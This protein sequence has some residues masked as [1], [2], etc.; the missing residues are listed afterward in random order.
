M[1]YALIYAAGLRRLEVVK[2]LL[3]ESPDLSVHEPIYDA[4]ARSV[5]AYQHYTDV[6]ALLGQ[7]PD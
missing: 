4:T 2:R 1:E 6:L 5:A 3:A 7:R